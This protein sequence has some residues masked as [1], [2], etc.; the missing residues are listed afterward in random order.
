MLECGMVVDFP[1]LLLDSDMINMITYFMQ[2]VKVSDETLCVDEVKAGGYQ[3]DYLMSPMTLKHMR[4]QSRPQ[5]FQRMNRTT[6]IAAGKPDPY[7]TAKERV[8]DILVNHQP[9]PLSG[10]VADDLRRFVTEVEKEWGVES[11][12]PNFDPATL[13]AGPDTD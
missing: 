6:W 1:Q 3:A 4:S 10:T 9:A 8:K 13:I 2:G 5:F 12:N 7:E 11:K